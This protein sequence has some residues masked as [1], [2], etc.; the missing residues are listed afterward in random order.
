MGARQVCKTARVVFKKVS[1]CKD[2]TAARLEEEKA[3]PTHRSS[4][5]VSVLIP[6]RAIRAAGI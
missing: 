5:L 3:T 1:A 2:I 4:R 6:V